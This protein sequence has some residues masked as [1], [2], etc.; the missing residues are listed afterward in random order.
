MKTTITI[1][2]VGQPAEEREVEFKER[3]RSKLAPGDDGP[4]YDQLRQLIEP[5]LD[6]E[7]LEHV[8]VLWEG[9]RRD[10]FVSELGHVTL[11]A[12]GPLPRNEEATAIYRANWLRGHPETDPESLAF[13]AGTAILFDERVWF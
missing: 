3:D 2:R 11:E 12:R 9:K 10:M 4:G 8:G 7:P 6:G 5:L 13:I 1:L